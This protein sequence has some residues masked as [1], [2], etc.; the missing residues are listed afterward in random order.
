M[1]Y[2][3]PEG[4]HLSPTSINL[5]QKCPRKFEF[6]FVRHIPYVHT[7]SMSVGIMVHSALEAYYG[8]VIAGGGRM[9][10]RELAAY[11][12]DVVVPGY[13]AGNE[14]LI[15]EKQ[16]RKHVPA[17]AAHYVE[18]LG[19]QVEPEAVEEG[20][21]RTFRCGLVVSGHIDLRCRLAKGSPASGIVDYKITSEK[22]Q[23]TPHRLA[24]SLQFHLYSY[25]TGLPLVTIHNCIKRKDQ[26]LPRSRLGRPSRDGV[27]AYANN[28]IALRHRFDA[29]HADWLEDI[30]ERAAALITAGIFLPCDPESWFCSRKGCEYWLLCRGRRH[31]A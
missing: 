13:L 22:R 16:C 1:P 7:P 14:H 29:R 4:Y 30:V 24:N 23:W 11:A 19:C 20:V 31:R 21:A 18:V 10:P 12:N 17:I 8:Q 5:L 28:I 26:P 6:K 2:V 27:T 15:S 9:A 3:L 25:M